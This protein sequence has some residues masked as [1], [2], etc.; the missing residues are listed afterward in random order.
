MAIIKIF[1]VTRNI[2]FVLK[3]YKQ[4]TEDLH[5][6]QKLARYSLLLY[7]SWACRHLLN[8]VSQ[9]RRLL[10]T[11]LVTTR[12]DST[13]SSLLDKLSTVF[14]K[15]SNHYQSRQISLFYSLLHIKKLLSDKFVLHLCF[16]NCWGIIGKNRK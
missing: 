13:W 1:W 9:F 11:V 6:Q 12:D 14:Y 10:F 7:C 16:R 3:C 4:S 2:Y 5:H 15:L 8:D